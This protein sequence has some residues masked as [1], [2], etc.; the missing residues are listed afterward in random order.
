MV[1]HTDISRREYSA[2]RLLTVRLRE[3]LTNHPLF[4]FS[5]HKVVI[6]NMWAM[7]HLEIWRVNIKRGGKSIFSKHI[8]S[9]IMCR[10]HKFL[11]HVAVI[12]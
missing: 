3:R 1:V 12:F 2:K 9:N 10:L 4:L 6:P 7:D 11:A 5:F 8:A